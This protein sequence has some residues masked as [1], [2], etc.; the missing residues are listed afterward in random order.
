[1]FVEFES[2]TMIIVRII[3]AHSHLILNKTA[4]ILIQNHF[5][6]LLNLL[7]LLVTIFWIFFELE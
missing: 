3:E 4:S 6:R 5:G 2:F 1:M 7:T